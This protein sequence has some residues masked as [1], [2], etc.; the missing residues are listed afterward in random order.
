M[1]DLR[2]RS[3]PEHLG[4]AD[5]RDHR[6]LGRRLAR[7]RDRHRHTRM[8]GAGSCHIPARPIAETPAATPPPVAN[9]PW[10]HVPI[11]LQIN[12]AALTKGTSPYGRESIP[13]TRAI[14]R[15]AL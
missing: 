1:A 11:C 4:G 7:Q 10:E 5:Q 8:A 14:L 13:P 12:S 9:R 15:A 2:W 3:R 6:T